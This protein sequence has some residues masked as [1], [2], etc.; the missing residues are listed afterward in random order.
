MRAAVAILSLLALA[1]CHERKPA[2]SHAPAA[3]GPV[4]PDPGVTTYVCLDGQRITAGYPDPRTA[5]V[6]YKDHA[7]TL[8]LAPSADGVRYTGYGLQWW[9]RGPHA[10]I[11]ALKGGEETASDP[12]LNCT[13]EGSPSAATV[14]RTSFRPSEQLR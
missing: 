4:N 6:T 13:A 8:K 12:G 2:S 11:A 14:T 3:A 1:A 10:A 7:Y 9:T 5:V